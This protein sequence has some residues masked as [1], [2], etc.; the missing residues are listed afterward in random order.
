MGARKGPLQVAGSYNRI[1][2]FIGRQRVLKR[3]ANFSQRWPVAR[4]DSPNS[5]CRDK[6]K[7]RAG[8][9]PISLSHTGPR[10]KPGTEPP[11]LPIHFLQKRNATDKNSLTHVRFTKLFAL[12]S[13]RSGTTS[14]RCTQW[15]FPFYEWVDLPLKI[16]FL[17]CLYSPV[18]QAS[19]ILTVKRMAGL[20]AD[21]SLPVWYMGRLEGNKHQT[22]RSF[23]ASFKCNK[24]LAGAC[25]LASPYICLLDT[26]EE[27]SALCWQGSNLLKGRLG[28]S[29]G[30][31]L[32]L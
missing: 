7:Q 3:T 23:Y 31:P 9:K 29:N 19:S 21:S 13:S 30:V 26:W 16:V 10:I 17:S 5:T 6:A 25:K 24:S 14:P 27:L 28:I 2:L 1:W 22:F 32:S 8:E 4:G 11:L 12:S 18:E 15:C 20:S